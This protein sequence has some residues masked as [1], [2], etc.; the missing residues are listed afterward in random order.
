[1]QKRAK[2]VLILG[3]TLV[4]LIFLFVNKVI[5]PIREEMNLHLDWIDGNLQ[6]S[7][8]SDGTFIVT[9][10]VVISENGTLISKLPEPIVITQAAKI[11]IREKTVSSLQWQDS[12]GKY[13]N[14]IGRQKNVKALFYR[15]Q[16]TN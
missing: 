12:T 14:V 7:T 11:V 1:M 16:M 3:V 15:P 6:F 4:S 13:N 10:L 9:H 2:A 8:L 5:I